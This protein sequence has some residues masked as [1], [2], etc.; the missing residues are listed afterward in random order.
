MQV[1]VNQGS[2]LSPLLFTIVL[3]VITENA[4]EGLMN[5]ILYGDDLVLMSE[6]FT[7]LELNLSF[8]HH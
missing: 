8:I 3:N 7:Y 1:R 5:E 6:H 2:V 4:K